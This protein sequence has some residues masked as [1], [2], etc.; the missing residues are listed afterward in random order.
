MANDDNLIE[1]S[2]PDI[3]GMDEIL[4]PSERPVMGKQRLVRFLPV[5]GTKQLFPCIWMSPYRTKEQIE[6]HGPVEQLVKCLLL[7]SKGPPKPDV[8]C[9]SIR[10]DDLGKFP[11]APVEW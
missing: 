1:I 9:I 4:R 8:V 7:V 10:P 2:I 11:V 3:Q 5:P 6:D